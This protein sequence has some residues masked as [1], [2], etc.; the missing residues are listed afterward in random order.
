VIKTSVR[1]EGKLHDIVLGDKGQLVLCHHTYDQLE[2]IH[3]AVSLGA[4]KPR[5]YEVFCAWTAARGRRGR[6]SRW[7]KYTPEQLAKHQADGVSSIPEPLKPLYWEMVKRTKNRAVAKSA[8]PYDKLLRTRDGLPLCTYL[9][10]GAPKDTWDDKA[11][12]MERLADKLQ[13]LTIKHAWHRAYGAGD[14]VAYVEA[15]AK[16]RYVPATAFKAA[17]KIELPPKIAVTRREDKTLLIHVRKDWWR[18]IA[19]NGL[20]VI[21][22]K[23]VMDLLWSDSGKMVVIAADNPRDGKHRTRARMALVENGKLRF[24]KP[25]EARAYAEAREKASKLLDPTVPFLGQSA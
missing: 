7:R 13:R 2:A 4:P 22:G 18:T 16:Q 23:F 6:L 17:H 8:S 25:K 5:C 21:D 14:R 12:R 3:A 24:L 15:R 20:S 19:A 10:N 1:C 11:H 9:A